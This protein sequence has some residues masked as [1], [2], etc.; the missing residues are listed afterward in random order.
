MSASLFRKNFSRDLDNCTNGK[1]GDR[2]IKAFF[3]GLGLLRISSLAPVRNSDE[4][5]EHSR[6]LQLF[7]LS[8][9]IEFDEQRIIGSSFLIPAGL[10]KSYLPHP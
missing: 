9:A 5:V 6:S 4:R 10:S 3:F 1:C 7:E 8:S 2:E